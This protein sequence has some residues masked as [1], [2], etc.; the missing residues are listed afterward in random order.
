MSLPWSKE[1]NDGGDTLDMRHDFI[2]L[3]RIRTESEHSLGKIPLIVLSKT[4]GIDDDEDYKPEQLA[5][6]RD[7]Q[8]QLATLSTNSE[9]ILVEHSGHH[10]QLDQPGIVIASILR[11]VDAAK[12]N[13]LLKD[14]PASGH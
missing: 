7:L 3:Y 4:P 10:I 13:R 8:N 1:R 6:N 14:E 9:H 5:W 11:V 12:H 2:D